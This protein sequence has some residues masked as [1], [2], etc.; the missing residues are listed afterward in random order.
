M[1][2]KL[3]AYLRQKGRP[4]SAEE[5]VRQVLRISVPSPALAEKLLASIAGQEHNLVR[6]GRGLWRLREE[7]QPAEAELPVET[8]FFL[9]PHSGQE[10]HWSCWSGIRYGRLWNGVFQL[11]DQARQGTLA[12]SLSAFAAERKTHPLVLSG[13]E[14]H[15]AQL[16]SA[17]RSLLGIDLADPVL[18]LRRLA[19]LVFPE[20]APTAMTEL[21]R[22][23]PG[24]GYAEGEPEVQLQAEAGLLLMLLERLHDK[25]VLHLSDLLRIY[26]PVRHQPDFTAFAFDDAFI[27]SL[28]HAPGVYVMRD[29]QERILYVGKAADLFERVGS[30]FRARGA[31]DEKLQTLWNQIHQLQIIRT[32]SELEALLLENRL[33]KELHPLINTQVKVFGRT[34]RRKSRFPRIVL[35]PSACDDSQA[36]YFLHPEKALYCCLLA[37]EEE[38]P[39]AA[40]TIFDRR[41][42]LNAQEEL[43]AEI[44]GYFFHPGPLLPAADERAEIAV[45]WLAAHEEQAE[46]IDMRGV[47][48]AA[49]ALR[50]IQAFLRDGRSNMKRIFYHS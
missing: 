38:S 27:A 4:A 28:P 23:L 22:L 41:L 5:L 45:S 14:Q 33:I 26:P 12:E 30:Y 11:A 39:S 34:H 48:C 37:A 9:R 18:T 24:A 49:E 32:G 1:M 19:E 21:T 44:D 43:E 17:S 47:L 29:R 10:G 2:D 50:T 40:W 46:S 7:A 31:V 15:A 16:R 35:L 25:G 8:F 13:F 42:S 3:A 36:L 6:D 20:N